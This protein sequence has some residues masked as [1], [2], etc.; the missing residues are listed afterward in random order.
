L[1]DHFHSFL[2]RTVCAIPLLISLFS[3]LTCYAANPVPT[4][5][6]PTHP[7]AV[8][9]GSGAFTLTVYG[10]NFVPGAVVKWN[11][12][13]RSTKFVSARELQAKILA[14]DVA[15]PTA[16]YITVTNPAPGG[17]P[18]SSSYAIVE[19]HTPTKTVAPGSPIW[20]QLGGDLI[21]FLTTG[22]FYN[23]HRL[24]LLA[25]GGT[26]NVYLLQSKGDGT[27]PQATVV[28]HD[29]FAADCQW[30]GS[31][32]VGDFNN[33]G[34]LD[35]LFSAGVPQQTASIHVRLGNGKGKFQ[36]SWKFGKYIG[37]PD[38]AVGDFN[39]DGNL[40]FAALADS[41]VHVFLG[42]GDGTFQQGATYSDLPA[43]FSPIVAD[44]NGDGKLDLVVDNGGGALQ[45][46][47][48][49]GDGTFQSPKTILA[50]TTGQALA[51]GYGVP[52]VANDFNSD[53]K[54]DLALCEHSLTGSWINILLGNGDGTFQKP[55]HYHAGTTDCAWPFATG[56]FNSDDNTDFIDWYC[57]NPPF[58]SHFATLRGNGN[59]TF[60]KQSAVFLPGLIED[61]GVVPGDWNADGLLDFVMIPGASGVQVYTQK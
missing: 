25:G 54:M 19:V 4:V 36:T 20:Y 29:Y 46:L 57:T 30:P 42:N 56:D 23:R 58:K 40:D 16:G 41:E 22:D 49:N 51:C 18:S 24:D 44:F 10:A 9:P 15:K 17:G 2:T 55:A 45:I 1:F 35:F 11:G 6:G 7:Q 37:C 38:F 3:V 26:G 33:D 12:S 53:G 50:A 31:L 60:Q 34:K 48:G 39:A 61:V 8:V 28:G 32:A 27:F 21:W 13:A 14:A 59:G 52:F 5:T 47:L 43:V